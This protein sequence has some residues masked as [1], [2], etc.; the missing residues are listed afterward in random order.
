MSQQGRSQGQHRGTCPR[1]SMPKRPSTPK[2]SH[3]FYICQPNYM[4]HISE[5]PGT[6]GS[7]CAIR[8]FSHPLPGVRS[9]P[10]PTTVSLYE[11]FE[12]SV[13]QY[14]HNTQIKFKISTSYA[15]GPFPRSPLKKFNLSSPIG[16]LSSRKRFSIVH[17]INFG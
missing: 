8:D 5:H 4:D 1:P 2:S 9:G 16:H 6:S 13:L 7:N 12:M 10:K 11:H 3:C 15:R 17:N 14:L